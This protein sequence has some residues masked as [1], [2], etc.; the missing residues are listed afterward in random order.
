M[1]KQPGANET[2]QTTQTTHIFALMLILATRRGS[3][4]H[5]GKSLK[6]FSFM[7]HIFVGRKLGDWF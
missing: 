5:A 1:Y 3:R 2:T 6:D 4:L 7:C